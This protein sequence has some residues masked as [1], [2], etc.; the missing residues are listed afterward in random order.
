MTDDRT[1]TMIRDF[2]APPAAV[3]R[4]WTDPELIPQWF[5]PAPVIT[6]KVEIDLR[7]GGSN[8]IVMQLPDGTE[9]P[10]R[11]VYLEVVPG[12]RLV[13]TD[14]FTQAWI[15]SQK[16]FLTI[17]IDLEDLPGGRTRATY[18]VRHWSAEDRKT[19][20]DMGFETGWGQCADQLNALLTR[21]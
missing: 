16:P 6:T 11:G 4:G 3:F 19:H 17:I 13:V 1:L 9:L 18:T 20:E 10:N 2:D 15:P 5:A 14:A 21:L 12:K 8:F 7:V